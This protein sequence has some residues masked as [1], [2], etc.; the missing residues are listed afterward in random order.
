VSRADDNDND[1]GDN[2]NG[3]DDNGD[4]DNG[5]NDNLNLNHTNH[6][7]DSPGKG[8]K[9]AREW[10]SHSLAARCVFSRDRI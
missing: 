8:G 3:D 5:D 10:C 7:D 2:D 1:N 9:P 6:G 4:N